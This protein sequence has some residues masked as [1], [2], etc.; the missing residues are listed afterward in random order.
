MRLLVCVLGII[1]LVP[2]PGVRAGAFPPPPGPSRLRIGVHV[3]D[4][5]RLYGPRYEGGAWE[6][7][8]GARLTQE[9]EDQLRATFP[10]DDS[11]SSFPPRGETPRIEAYIVV[12]QAI[13]RFYGRGSMTAEA[14]TTVSVYDAGREPVKD[15]QV[16]SEYKVSFSKDTQQARCDAAVK[17]LVRDLATKLIS[18]LME[19]ELQAQLERAAAAA[20]ARR[21]RP[22]PSPA[23][24]PVAQVF[25]RLV[26][27]VAPVGAQVFLDDVYWGVSKAESKLT[28]AGVTAGTHTLRVSARGYKELRQ[29]VT[30]AP[31]DNPVALKAEVA[32][33]KPLRE[34]EVE[35][36]LRWDVPKPRINALI[37]QY[38]V[39]FT[40]TK[41][42]EIRLLDAGADQEMLLLIASNKK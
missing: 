32:P 25:G 5:V 42:A 15:I 11:L 10:N 20:R 28:I 23:P 1:S 41:A 17:E 2:A 4:S 35:D 31:G 12:E 8:F 13:A 27:E 29:A 33:P 6:S 39:D 26:L 7:Q 19:P 21:E 22:A 24:T 14:Q 38:G 9:I 18:A 30:V 37:K 3:R 16:L 34:A 40:L 36:A